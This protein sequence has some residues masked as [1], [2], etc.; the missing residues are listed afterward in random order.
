MN[1]LQGCL[2]F[3]FPTPAR[4]GVGAPSALTYPYRARSAFLSPAEITFYRV[5]QTAVASRYAIFPKVRLLDLCD[6]TDRPVNQTA[7]NRIDR[8]HVDFLLCDPTT[9]KPLKAIELDDSTHERRRRADR[10][11]F[12]DQIFQVIGLP[13]VHI[14]AQSGYDP[15]ELVRRLDLREE[16]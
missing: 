13:L 16:S 14:Q 15:Q 3:L 12:V 10:D 7:M 8:K 1:R 2:G 5:L 6:V 4:T 11:A 9:F